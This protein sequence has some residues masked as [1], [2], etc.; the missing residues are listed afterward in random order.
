MQFAN[1]AGT[2]IFGTGSEWF[3][4]MAQFIVVVV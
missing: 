3:W 1:L 4:A 2:S